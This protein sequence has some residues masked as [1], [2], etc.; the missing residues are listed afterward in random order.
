M[1]FKE[2]KNKWVSKWYAHLIPTEEKFVGCIVKNISND[3]LDIKFTNDYCEHEDFEPYC[4]Y[5]T[6]DDEPI[7]GDWIY[8]L[9]CNQMNCI[10]QIQSIEQTELMK[11]YHCDKNDFIR[12]N[13]K[14]I[15]AT[16]DINIES[17]LDSYYKN[18]IGS[19]NAVYGIH[20]DFLNSFITSFNEKN[21]KY[22]C[23]VWGEY[24]KIGN[25]FRINSSSNKVN[26][27]LSQI[28]WDR[29]D[30]IENIEQFIDYI[31]EKDSN[32]NPF[33]LKK[34]L[35]IWSKKHL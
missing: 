12:D 33:H 18:G 16:N 7:K 3:R 10:Q 6:S 28:M 21:I 24:S 25:D 31:E 14:K 15:V 23:D 9:G 2:R 35:D 30:L 29:E 34:M 11:I 22:T 20:N 4:L 27:E 8:V 26:P 13:I 32:I 17:Q 5:L 19:I 1:K